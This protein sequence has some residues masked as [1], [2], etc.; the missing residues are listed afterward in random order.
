MFDDQFEVVSLE[1]SSSFRYLK[2]LG[3]VLTGRLEG[4][5]G[6]HVAHTRRAVFAAPAAAVHVQVD[7]EYAGRLPATVEIAPA[8]LTIPVPR[9]ARP[10]S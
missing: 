5:R 8:A 1:G 3:G 2:Y 10:G 4:M 6:V 7:G 9:P